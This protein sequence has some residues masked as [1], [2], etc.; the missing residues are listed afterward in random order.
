MFLIITLLRGVQFKKFKSGSKGVHK[1]VLTKIL[2]TPQK[3]F[4]FSP[5]GV[6]CE[7]EKSL[8]SRVQELGVT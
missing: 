2:L 8:F 6:H 1:G 3:F 5:T 7:S 4:S